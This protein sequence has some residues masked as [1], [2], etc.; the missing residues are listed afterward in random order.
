MAVSFYRRPALERRN[1]MVFSSWLRNGK[2]AGPAVPRRT[3]TSPR[4]RARFRPHVESLEDRTV[5][6]GYQQM[7][8][9]GYQPGQGHFTD[10]NLNGWGMTSMP[11]GSFCVANT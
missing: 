7:N 3:Q 2:R 4:Q 1:V 9:V 11:D 10:P 6:S 5:P 8:L